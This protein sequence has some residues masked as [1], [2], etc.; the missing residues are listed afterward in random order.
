MKQVNEFY[1]TSSNSKNLHFVT[2]FEF[3]IN[4]IIYLNIKR[5]Q[6]YKDKHLYDVEVKYIKDKKEYILK[7]NN[8][9][10]KS[11]FIIISDSDNKSDFTITK[12]KK[13]KTE[14]LTSI[15]S[16]EDKNGGTIVEINKLN[17]GDI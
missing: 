12:L 5:K 7:C 14:L 13:R 8:A 1:L 6:K 4:D 11:L 16:T 17:F 3:S 10:I 15:N 9:I 2:S